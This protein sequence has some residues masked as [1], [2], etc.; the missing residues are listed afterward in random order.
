LNNK[1]DLS[2]KAENNALLRDGA[3]GAGDFKSLPLENAY[4]TITAWLSVVRH[5]NAPRLSMCIG[6]GTDFDLA[7]HW[8]KA[9]GT[10]NL[11]HDRA[12]TCTNAPHPRANIQDVQLVLAFGSGLGRGASDTQSKVAQWKANGARIVSINPVKSGLSAIADVWVSIRP[13]CDEELM[14]LVEQMARGAMPDADLFGHL[15]VAQGDAIA[16]SHALNTYRGQTVILTGRGVSAHINGY[17]FA[18]SIQQLSRDYDCDIMA[19]SDQPSQPI[20]TPLVDVRP[21]A[22]LCLNSELAGQ[23]PLNPKAAHQAWSNFEG[24]IVCFE[25]TPTRFHKYADMVITGP[26]EEHLLQL[27]ARLGLN[28][29]GDEDG[30][31]LFENGYEDYAAPAVEATPIEFTL[32]AKNTVHSDEK[33]PLHA[34]SIKAHDGANKA[35]VFMHPHAAGERDLKDKDQIIVKS[36]SGTV[37]A[38][39][40]TMADM[41]VDTIWTWGGAL[42]SQIMPTTGLRD[43]SSDQ[44]AWFDL[45][46]EVSKA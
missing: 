44:P 36:A 25:D 20:L 27:G 9:F 14:L 13:G 37:K 24:H 34:I 42:F 12:I 17:H 29:F 16:L 35:I 10:K 38:F 3:R 5:E 40:V 1:S 23:V 6:G 22:L 11:W 7:R 39:V 26:A 30:N 41:N 18:K 33:F 4:R 21:A 32:A 31:S 46:V 15:G 8:A 2:N 28:Q 45:M 43:Q 19:M